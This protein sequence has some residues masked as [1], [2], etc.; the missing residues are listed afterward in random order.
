MRNWI[1][2]LESCGV[3]EDWQSR[4]CD[5]FADTS[6]YPDEL[7]DVIDCLRSGEP[8]TIDQGLKL[9]H[10]PDL[11]L[12][13]HLA[14]VCKY[15]R[16]GSDVFFNSNLH[17]NQTNICTLACKFCAFRRGPKA[18][19]AYALSID[20]F[21]SRIKPHA[22]HIDEVHTVGGLHP[23]WDVEYY[24]DLFAAVKSE[25]ND[26]HIKSLSAV[27]VK[28]IAELS[29][30]SP[31]SLLS[32]LQKSGLDSLPGGGAEILDDRVRNIICNGKETSDE[33]ISIHRD[34]HSIGMPTNCTM[35]FATIETPLERISHLC[36]LRDL[37]AE[38]GG[39]QCFVPY[40]YLPDNS[41]LPEAQL[42]SSSEV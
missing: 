2:D 5:S 26:I 16:F 9:W 23:D 8:L 32:R 6:L 39:F 31:R 19:D 41:R 37:Q 22:T 36:K 33:Y 38:T 1:S 3:R 40:P 27:E 7:K 10:Y 25:Y 29:G 35:L 24:E 18:K 15:S 11:S 13:G 17:V 20:E 34:A 28:H 14:H 21:L 42:A 12:I 30:I 4:L